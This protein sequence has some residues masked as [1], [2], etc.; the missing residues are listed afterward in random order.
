MPLTRQSTYVGK[1]KSTRKYVKKTT[2]RGAYKP[3]RK[4]QMMIRR[5][6]FVETKSRT[7]EEIYTSGV[8]PLDPTDFNTIPNSDGQDPQT[9]TNL[10]VWSICSQKQGLGEDQIIGLSCYAKYL[11]AKLQFKLPDGANSIT[12]VADMYLIHGFIKAPFGRTSFTNPTA[13]A[14]TRADFTGWVSR[15]L[16]DFFD[17]R[18]DKLR[19]IPKQNT[20]LRILGYKKIQPNRNSNIGVMN[21]G[22]A[23]GTFPMINMSCY[24]PM[25]KKIYYTPGT[26]SN[27]SDQ[28]LYPNSQHIPFMC[29]YNPTAGEFTSGA[30]YSVKVAYNDC[31]WYSDS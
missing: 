7:H 14:T 3:A 25:K 11:K 22:N 16:K 27:P 5:A 10:P 1:R 30:D 12:H 6:P 8:L 26:G 31:V 28:F 29:V 9:V 19:F 17:E 20:N 18:E 4:K 15:H 23:Q 24:W 2:R 13:Q 21:I